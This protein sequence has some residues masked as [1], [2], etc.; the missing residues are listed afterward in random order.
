MGPKLA[1]APCPARLRLAR[2]IKTVTT[3]APSIRPAA[4]R[5]ARIIATVLVV[6]AAMALG[7]VAGKWQ[8]G[9]YETKVQAVDAQAAAEGK[10]VADIEDLIDRDATDPGDADWRTATV[11][12][13]FDPDSLTELRGR[14][15][16]NT[17]TLQYLVW[18]RTP[19]GRAV[20]VNLGWQPRSHATPPTLRAERITV[21]GVVRA[22]ESD[23]G[24]PGTRITPTQMSSVDGEVIPAYLMARS[25]CGP[26]GCLDGVEPVPTPSLSLGPHLSY[27]L[28]W[29]LLT[30]VAA[31]L[32][33]W[34]TR[35]DALHER[36]RAR[37]TADAGGAEGTPAPAAKMRGKPAKKRRTPTDEEVEDAL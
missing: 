31:P 11:T 34:V 13:S 30:V 1:D 19:S 29:W 22:F 7:L 14:S 36:E 26:A 5:P 24:R 3:P 21:T 2:T 27:A 10:P 37:E 23:N 33:I 20:M 12:G 28:Q 18:V 32:G 6:V 25:T 17:A 8:W 9:R 15:V 4:Y 16:D 35:R